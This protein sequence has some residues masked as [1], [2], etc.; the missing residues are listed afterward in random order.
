MRKFSR[1]I[2]LCVLLVILV[3]AFIQFRENQ[4]FFPKNECRLEKVEGWKIMSIKES[5]VTFSEAQS[6]LFLKK[7]RQENLPLSADFSFKTS[8]SADTELKE[9]ICKV[10]YKDI[11]IEDVIKDFE[12]STNHSSP[13]LSGKFN[14]DLSALKTEKSEEEIFDFI[15]AIFSDSQVHYSIEPVW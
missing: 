7:L 9:I 4:P 1:Y 10:T 11:E 2:F 12:V 15:K 8:L 13:I 5:G 14:Y 3:F 6:A